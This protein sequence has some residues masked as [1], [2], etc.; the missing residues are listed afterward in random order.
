MRV[1]VLSYRTM[2][3]GANSTGY[4]AVVKTEE[5]WAEITFI[6]YP[7]KFGCGPRWLMALCRGVHCRISGQ[8]VCLLCVFKSVVFVCRDVFLPLFFLKQ[9]LHAFSLP[10]SG[11]LS[12]PFQAL[13]LQDRAKS[14]VI[15]HHITRLMWLI[16]VTTCFPSNITFL[17]VSAHQNCL[18]RHVHTSSNKACIHL[19]QACSD[20]EL[21][22]GQY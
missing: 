9:L 8:K 22:Q 18:H 21:Q 15:F 14:F 7:Y 6:I 11:C 16:W 2:Q 1:H 17:M 19:W 13:C 10:H 20:M 3:H 4:F 5:R 12:V